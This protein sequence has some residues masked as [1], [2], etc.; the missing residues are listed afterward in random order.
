LLRQV[1][2]G[3]HAMHAGKCARRGGAHGGDFCVGVRAAHEGRVQ[4]AGQ[5]DV[6]D[7]AAP[8]GEQRRI[9]LAL[10]R[11]AEP[12]RS[13]RMLPAALVDCRC[14]CRGATE[15]RTTSKMISTP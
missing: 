14:L 12:F 4:R 15:H 9:L 1:G 11:R 3:E 6:V 8:A 7:E 10:D 2:E 5:P 13:H